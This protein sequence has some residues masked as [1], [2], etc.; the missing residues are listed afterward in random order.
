MGPGYA[1]PDHTLV[2]EFLRWYRA[3]SD[4]ISSQLCGKVVWWI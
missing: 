4:D 2:K 3:A 1:T